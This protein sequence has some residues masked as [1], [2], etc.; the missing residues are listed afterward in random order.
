V[1][2]GEELFPLNS[3]KFSHN[4]EMFFNEAFILKSYLMFMMIGSQIGNDNIKKLIPQL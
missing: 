2:E 4:T 1:K 3:P